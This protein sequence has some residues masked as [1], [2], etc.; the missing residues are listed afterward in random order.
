MP[1][2]CIEIKHV[3]AR[4]ISLYQNAINKGSGSGIKLLNVKG[5]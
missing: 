1:D 3:K 2:S 4:Y 5:F